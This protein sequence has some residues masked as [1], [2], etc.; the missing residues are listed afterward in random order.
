MRGREGEKCQSVNWE[1]LYRVGQKEV[2]SISEGLEAA[3]RV[4][5]RGGG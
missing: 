5:P 1:I 2:P 3:Y 4:G